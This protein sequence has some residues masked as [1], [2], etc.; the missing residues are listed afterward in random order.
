MTRARSRPGH[1][2]TGA[3]VGDLV[4][5]PWPRYPGQPLQAPG[6]RMGLRRL[7][8]AR[9]SDR[10]QGP[11]SSPCLPAAR[12]GTPAT[13]AV[14]LRQRNRFVV[15]VFMVSRWAP[16]RGPSRRATSG[17]RAGR[18]RSARGGCRVRLRPSPTAQPR[19]S[20][21]GHAGPHDIAALSRS[22]FPPLRSLVTPGRAALPG[23]RRARS[24][25]PACSRRAPAAWSGWCS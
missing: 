17:P 6:P 3:A 15:P 22:R 12:R 7:A 4:A 13:V 2:V 18:P 25:T 19:H 20:A 9:A 1:C 8:Q 23:R 21:S 16:P 24:R 10:L 14:L 11:R 5:C